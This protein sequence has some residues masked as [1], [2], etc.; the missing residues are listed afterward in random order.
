[1]MKNYQMMYL[2]VVILFTSLIVNAQTQN[3]I[4]GVTLGGGTKGKGN[5]SMLI[6]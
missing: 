1:M 2:I 5:T 3:R 6:Y 4:W